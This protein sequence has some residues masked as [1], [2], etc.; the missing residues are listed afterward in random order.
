MVSNPDNFLATTL[1]ALLVT[2]LT[3][4]LAL[5]GLIA[6]VVG[7]RAIHDRLRREEPNH[8]LLSYSWW[9]GSAGR[10]TQ[11]VSYYINKYGADANVFWAI[12][13]LAMMI[14]MLYF[15]VRIAPFVL[16]LWP[17]VAF[18]GPGAV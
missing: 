6:S 1:F 5:S 17:D 4:L 11:V 9:S 8:A 7:Y 2:I 3:I 10:Q 14:P 18:L 15:G 12:G 13:G 16:D